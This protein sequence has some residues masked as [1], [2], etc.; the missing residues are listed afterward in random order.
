MLSSLLGYLLSLCELFNIT[1][2]AEHAAH[3]A[4]ICFGED[5]KEGKQ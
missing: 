4:K 2:L 1:G 5:L 3:V